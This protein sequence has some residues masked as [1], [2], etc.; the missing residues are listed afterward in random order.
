MKWTAGNDAALRAAL[1]RHLTAVQA[2]CELTVKFGRT[3]TRNAVIGRADRLGLRCD[4]NHPN[5]TRSASARK[6]V[7]HVVRAPRI[8]P[9]DRIN[10]HAMPRAERRGPP[11]PSKL[12]ALDPPPELAIPASGL[13]TLMDLRASMCKWPT[14]HPRHVGFG[15][16][17][18]PKSG[19]WPYC[20]HHASIAYAS[21]MR[22][23]QGVSV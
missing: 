16:C 13:V 22:I 4:S 20:A 18:A 10:R 11:A 12:V 6:F 19:G 21:P 2:A 1:G 14:G 3:V 7:A 23:G 8:L 9:Q 5:N 17:G 15:F